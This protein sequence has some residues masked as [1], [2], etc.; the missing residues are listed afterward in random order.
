MGKNGGHRDEQRSQG[1]GDNDRPW[2]SRVGSS[3]TLREM[4]VESDPEEDAGTF[5]GN[6][7]QGARR[8]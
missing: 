1:G 5:E 6:A 2:I 7:H 3:K 4:G 8:A